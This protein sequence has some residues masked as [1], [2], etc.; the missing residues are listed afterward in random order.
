[1]WQ[2]LKHYSQDIELTQHQVPV[3]DIALSSEFCTFPFLFV[4]RLCLV[5]SYDLP[6]RNIDSIPRI[7]AVK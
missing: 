4:I 7:S 6:V 3:L 5:L 1:V 2:V